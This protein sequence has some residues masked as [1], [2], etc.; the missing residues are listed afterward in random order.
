[1]VSM[2]EIADPRNSY[3]LNITRYI[4]SAHPEDL[5]D[6]HAHLHGGTPNADLDALTDY[7]DAFPQLRGQ[8]FKPNRPGYSDLAIDVGDVHQ[9]ILDSTE[10][11]KFAGDVNGLTADW[12]AT[13]R[14][15]LAAIDAD[16]RP[17]H[18][19]TAIGDELL[20]R[21]E[22]VPLL[23]QYDVYEQLMTYWHDTMHDDFSLVIHEGWLEAAK[24]RKTI[25]DKE[26]KL[27]ETP[28]LVVGSGRSVAKYKMDLIP[29]ALIVARYFADDQ[30]VVDEL[31]AELESASAAVTEHVEEHGIDDALLCD[32]T[33]EK[34]AYTKQLLTDAMKSARAAG[35]DEVLA[36]ADVA[37]ALLNAEAG[38]RKTVKDAQAEL[39]LATL[40]KYGALTEDD[41][42]LLV[43][44]DK[45][46]AVVQG[47]ISE[48]AVALTLDLVDRLQQLGERYVHTVGD[49]D[50]AVAKV[51]AEVTSHLAA[52]GIES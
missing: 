50:T 37:L 34:G 6:L 3:N 36:C 22:P 9:A 30:A 47:R 5:Q 51:E 31:T 17:Q 32:A 42:R 8:I 7:W 12:I 23:D 46:S 52:M 16:T 38:A 43:I 44:D 41:I 39:D 48:E 25:E 29:P 2:S 35:D 33:T 14:D 1:M 40:R 19:I 10:F 13:H 24:P 45:W 18:L 27:S 26:R 21:F 11:Q 20:A 4:D 49:L 15:A 28:D